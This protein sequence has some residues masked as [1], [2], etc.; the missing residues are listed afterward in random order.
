MIMAI[1]EIISEG[2]KQIYKELL[3]DFPEYFPD[4]VEAAIYFIHTAA[5]FNIRREAAFE[6]FGLTFGRFTLLMLLRGEANHSLSPSELA[7]R[8]Q[9]GRATMTQFID[10]LEK[11]GL[12]KRADDSRD[13]RAT[14]VE[15]TS[16]GEG[17]LKRT[18]PEF[19]KTLSLFT[20]ILNRNER[21]QLLHLMEKLTHGLEKTNS[22][23]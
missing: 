14:L 5:Q 3:A 23:I 7:K 10:A 12:V 18:I 20:K 13:R 16:K 17:L 2:K 22:D 6:R 21:K 15:L 4:A 1:L 9:V 8:S 19:L 11:D